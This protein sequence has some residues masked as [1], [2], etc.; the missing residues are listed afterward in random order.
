MRRNIKGRSE[1]K[2]HLSNLER[3]NNYKFGKEKKNEENTRMKI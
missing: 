3:I 2:K 1:G